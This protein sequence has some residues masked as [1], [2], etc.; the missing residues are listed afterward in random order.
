[1]WTAFSVSGQNDQFLSQ[2]CLRPGQTAV[3]ASPGDG[4]GKDQFRSLSLAKT[5]LQSLSDH[6]C[7][8]TLARSN[9]GPW[10]SHVTRPAA[11]NLSKYESC[12]ESQ[13]WPSSFQ[14]WAS[15]LKPT[16]DE[17]RVVR[18][19]FVHAIGLVC[20][21]AVCLKLRHGPRREDIFFA[22]LG[23]AHFAIALLF[24]WLQPA[25]Y[26]RWRTYINTS[27]KICNACIG[28][29]LGVL[30]LGTNF[31]SFVPA[32]VAVIPSC[33]VWNKVLI[34]VFFSL[35]MP[36]PLWHHIVFH[37]LATAIVATNSPRL[38]ELT[39]AQI[40]GSMEVFNRVLGAVLHV[41]SPVIQTLGP[42]ASVR[43]GNTASCVAVQSSLQILLGFFLPTIILYITE[44]FA[45][46]SIPEAT[47]TPPD[48]RVAN[49]LEWLLIPLLLVYLCPYIMAVTSAIVSMF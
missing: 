15:D 10:A 16:F 34:L 41:S 11:K 48:S 32:W 4:F 33:I 9:T 2:V 1:M 23:A 36:L 3:A 22:S 20:W 46:D 31:A 18:D 47:G 40:P 6:A 45:R 26:L 24:A 28:N 35:W 30:P 7:C 8:G 44:M 42:V 12:S 5:D 17:K 27:I 13:E 21:L 29:V 19:C 39:E 49:L 43:L 25:K 37:G 38:C 14:H